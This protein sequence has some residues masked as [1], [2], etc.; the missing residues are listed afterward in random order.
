MDDWAGAVACYELALAVWRG[1]AADREGHTATLVDLARAVAR[2]GR[3]PQARLGDAGVGED[4]GRVEVAEFED[5]LP[6]PW[7]RRCGPIAA[8]AR[9]GK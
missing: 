2:G 7:G 9:S 1:P 6:Q 4:D 5:L 3:T 8:S